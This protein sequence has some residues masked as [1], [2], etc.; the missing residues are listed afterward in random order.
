MPALSQEEIDEYS[1][2]EHDRRV[3]IEAAPLTLKARTY[4]MRATEWLDEHRERLAAT[5]DAVVRDALEIVAWDAY[6]IGAKLHRALSGRVRLRDDDDEGDDHPI[7]NDSNGSAK[8]ALISLER[9]EAAWQIIALASGDAGAS[10][11]AESAAVLR[12]AVLDEFTDAMAFIR[13]AF[14]QMP[15]GR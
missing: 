13:P 6:L 1:R 4:M 10:V 15:D 2:A 5:A 3:R 7:Q 11:L 14:D 12:H 8:V 9:S